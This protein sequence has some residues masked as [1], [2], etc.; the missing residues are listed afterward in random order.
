M[1]RRKNA[2]IKKTMGGS[3]KCVWTL[4][5]R[6]KRD[7][8]QQRGTNLSESSF[9]IQKV[10]ECGARAQIGLGSALRQRLLL[11]RKSLVV[12][13]CLSLFGATSALAYTSVANT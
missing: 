8:K 12:G 11:F 7:L 3:S 2:R 9:V 6:S 4:E 13:R 10:P 1:L 5:V